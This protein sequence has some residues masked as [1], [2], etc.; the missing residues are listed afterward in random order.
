[1]GEP[2]PW[3]EADVKTMQS[4]FLHAM[5][6]RLAA[7]TRNPGNDEE[8]RKP[9]AS[10]NDALKKLSENFD[11]IDQVGPAIEKANRMKG[12]EVDEQGRPKEKKKVAYADM[13]DSML[14]DLQAG[15][16]KKSQTHR[17]LDSLKK[18]LNDME[19]IGTRFDKNTQTGKQKMDKVNSIMDKIQKAVKGSGADKEMEKQKE[20]DSTGGF[21]D[22][23]MS[24]KEMQQAHGGG[25]KASEIA[26]DFA[27]RYFKDDED[28]DD[29]AEGFDASAVEDTD[30]SITR[31][32]DTA[33]F[34]SEGDQLS[35][36]L[37]NTGMSFKVVRMDDPEYAQLKAAAMQQ[38]RAQAHK[39]AERAVN[40]NAEEDDGKK[41]DQE[42]QGVRSGGGNT[43][44]AGGL[45]DILR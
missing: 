13:M 35:Q 29:T 22:S 39:M 15:Q 20:M 44:P 11:S 34:S 28:D 43:A 12:A 21:Y 14:R 37:R 42:E 38:R 17:T 27:S 41:Q 10:F 3:S 36:A 32:K 18:I 30:R 6:Q 9:S 8:L 33:A 45:F 4:G 2:A 40:A 16:P 31:E 5:N 1:M 26:A 19:G 25:R 23:N 24:F 7:D